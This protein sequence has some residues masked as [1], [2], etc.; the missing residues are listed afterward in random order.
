MAS[1]SWGLG[2]SST[3]RLIR[4]GTF[5]RSLKIS[6]KLDLYCDASRMQDKESLDKAIDSCMFQQEGEIDC[7]KNNR[8]R[9]TKTNSSPRVALVGPMT[10]RDDAYQQSEHLSGWR[11]VFDL[12][13]RYCNRQCTR[14]LKV[15]ILR[16]SSATDSSRA[17]LVRAVTSNSRPRMMKP[18]SES[19]YAWLSISAISFKRREESYLCNLDLEDT[20]HGAR[21]IHDLE[22]LSDRKHDFKRDVRVAKFARSTVKRET[23][24]KIPELHENPSQQSARE[25]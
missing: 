3:S 5:S 24:E 10:A 12:P 1:R 22:W 16:A 2:S 6:Q 11:G 19:S 8:N 25:P 13:L 15:L 14:V 20:L 7:S 4:A 18:S 17:S 9:S 21:R 23:I